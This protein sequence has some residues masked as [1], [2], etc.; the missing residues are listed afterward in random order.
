M[1]LHTYLHFDGNTREAFEFYAR[2]LGGRIV[3]MMSFGSTP[4]CEHVPPESHDKIMHA[5]LEIDGYRLMATDGIPSHPHVPMAGAHVVL[6]VATPERAEAC[7]AA[8]AEGGRIEMPIGP[9][10][11][12]QRY[13]QLTDRYGTAWMINCD[14]PQG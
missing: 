4:A 11:W 7:F 9:T 8:L 5:Q 13:G 14:L 3:A 6:D 12:A 2:V 10:F 1:K